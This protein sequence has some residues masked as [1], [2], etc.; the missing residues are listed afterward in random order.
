[1][2]GVA[3]ATAAIVCVLSVFNGFRSVLAGKLSLLSPQVSVRP[4]EGKALQGVD[5]LCDR[6]LM[7]SEIA[8]AAP[9][10]EDRTLALYRGM[11][12]PVRLIGVDQDLFRLYTAV[13]SIIVG[14][15]FRL[16]N[17]GAEASSE[18]TAPVEVDDSEFSAEDVLA[19]EIASDSGEISPMAVIG[20]GVAQRLNVRTP[21]GLN[22]GDEPE[23]KF[24]LFSPRRHGQIN[25]V[26]PA[27]SII[28]EDMYVA[29]VFQ[30]LQ[31]DYDKDI[32]IVSTEVARD[33][34]EYDETQATSIDLTASPGVS[35]EQL[36]AAAG[37]ILGDNYSIKTRQQQ[38]DTHFK[39]VNIEKWVTFLLLA[40]ILLIASFNVVS[41]L[42]IL[43]L[44]K[45]DNL[46]SLRALGMPGSRIGHVFAWES[47]WV[48]TIGGGIGIL[49][50]LI[51]SYAQQIFGFIK[52]SGDP[53]TLIMT[54]YP[55]QVNL[56]DVPVVAVPLICIGACTAFFASRFAR[57]RSNW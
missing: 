18:V 51:L 27:G 16:Y 32:V 40:F 39:M 43:V 31:S 47:F 41:S 2:V 53:S 10:I 3:V 5:T 4:L 6:L 13:D 38:Q 42:A 12:M 22:S 11:E 19:R 7:S 33:M 36:A 55:V 26:N 48:M 24:I 49:L 30:S 52:L 45:E 56:R 9:R 25:M 35:D 15:N 57:S 44:D 54:S 34:L 37:E 20:V 21:F 14:G 29:G 50:G 8:L 17:N 23:E 46:R 28:R 1:M